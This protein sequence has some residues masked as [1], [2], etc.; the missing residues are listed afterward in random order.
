MQSPERLITFLS[1]FGTSDGYVASVKG[2]IATA[3]P[4]ARVVDACHHIA[5]QD[6]LSAAY[7]LSTYW[8]HYPQGT[9]HLAVVDPGVG[10]QRQILAATVEG[11]LFVAPDN[12][13]LSYVFR[14]GAFSAY[15]LEDERLH[16]RNISQ[17]FHGRDIMGPLAA[18]LACGGS[19]QAVGP[20]ITAPVVL[21]GLEASRDE[22][23][24]LHG[25][26]VH[27]DHFGNAISNIRSEM[28]RGSKDFSV[29]IG[30]RRLDGVF[31]YYVQAG[32]GRPAALLGSSGHLEIAVPGG[33]AARELGIRSGATLR[34]MAL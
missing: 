26:I 2:V 25:Q 13:L 30:G 8:R 16:L 24:V 27:I 9:V 21:D 32:W 7:V 15:C 34:V 17:T 29:E 20:A 5:P 33:S 12:G 1:D 23:G 19:V 28:L 6:V 14:E 31:D 4:R 3:A 22:C 11:H 18:Y 10:S